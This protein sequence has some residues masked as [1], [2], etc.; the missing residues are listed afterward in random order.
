MNA[1]QPRESPAFR[2][3]EE[4]NKHLTAVEHDWVMW[5]Y[6]G[7]TGPRRERQV[8][9]TADD[10]VAQAVAAYREMAQ[11]TTEIALACD[12]LHRPGVRSLREHGPA[13]SLR[14]VLVHLVE[15]TA[16][17]AGH[18]DILREQIDGAVGR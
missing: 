9:I 6:R 8:R 1:P 16:R 17:H 12:D 7:E 15:E 2:R 13:P 3:G 4:V 10:T 18:A 11:R 14:W 5:A